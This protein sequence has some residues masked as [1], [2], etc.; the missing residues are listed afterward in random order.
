MRALRG[1]LE[2]PWNHRGRARHELLLRPDAY[3]ACV[4]A[5]VRRAPAR[6]R[7]K[8]SRGGYPRACSPKWSCF[9]NPATGTSRDQQGSTDETDERAAQGYGIPTGDRQQLPRRTGRRGLADGP[10][11]PR[12]DRVPRRHRRSRLHQPSPAARPAFG[13]PV[14][15][16]IRRATKS[17]EPS[18]PSQALPQVAKTINAR[19]KRAVSAASLR[20][21]N[22]SAGV[23]TRFRLAPLETS[24]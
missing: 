21:L 8:P 16:A 11:T 7:G 1:A 17:F 20:N 4:S 12:P 18:F 5:R 22:T 23:A 9:E 24:A 15:T 14:D 19:R 2:P 3:F 6:A 13:D 10:W